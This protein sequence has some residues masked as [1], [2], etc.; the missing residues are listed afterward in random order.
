MT[1]PNTP[2]IRTGPDNDTV[3]TVLR[4]AQRAPS[5]HN[6]Q[7]WHWTFDGI[8]LHLHTDPDRMLPAT[9]PHGR[10]QVISCGA[11]LHH[12][13]TAFAAHGW[14]TDTTRMPDPH[15]P[16][17]LAAI[18][19]RPWPNPPAGVATRAEMIARR[20]TDRLPLLPP[21]GWNGLLHSLRKLASPHETTLDVLDK[22][23]RARLAGL[24]AQAAAA[25]KHDDMYQ[26]ELHWWA[27]HSGV[28]EGVP[29][30]AL[31]SDA[32][33]ARVDVG[34]VFPSAPHSVRRAELTDQAEVVALGSTGESVPHWLHTGE[35]LSAI[36]LECTTAGLATC[37]VTHV[38]ELAAGRRAIAD[39]LPHHAV[40]QAVI[41]IGTAPSDEPELPPTPRRPLADVL[42]IR[43]P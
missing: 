23:T 11:V 43:R 41:R 25:R 12:A 27:G 5:V 30:S 33:F 18:E 29:R 4:L 21:Q 24:S 2:D 34:R 22:S 16:N 35:A 39:L 28:P 36:L 31:V 38:T 14:H 17:Y 40:P 8:R 10:Q 9:D 37:A 32:E 6:T 42:T 1:S 7:P 19:F 3:L 13:R 15:R 20:R 26:M